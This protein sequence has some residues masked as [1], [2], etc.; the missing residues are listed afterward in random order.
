MVGASLQSMSHMFQAPC[1]TCCMLQGSLRLG[2]WTSLDMSHVTSSMSH[3]FPAPC[4]TY[5]KL[6]GRGTFHDMSH[7]FKLHVTHVTGSMSH[8]LKLHVTH[9]ASSTEV[10][11]L[12][13]EPEGHSS[14]RSH[15]C[16]VSS[17]QCPGSRQR[18]GRLC[19]SCLWNLLQHHHCS[20]RGC[21]PGGGAGCCLRPHRCKVRLGSHWLQMY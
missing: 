1:H 10:G 2:E 13:A 19:W 14:S 12:Q 11:H 5:F 18:F 8:M 20:G 7:M 9:I 21:A 4:H 3:M 15:V 17:E 6:Q 16:A